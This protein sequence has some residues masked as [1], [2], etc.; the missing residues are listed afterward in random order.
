[1]C[2]ALE[3][4]WLECTRVFHLCEVRLRDKIH[5]PVDF[6]LSNALMVSLMLIASYSC[7][8]FA[9]QASF[10]EVRNSRGLKPGAF[11]NKTHKVNSPDPF[12]QAFI[13]SNRFFYPRL[14]R[15]NALATTPSTK[16]SYAR[17]LCEHKYTE[18]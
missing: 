16:M 17:L 9:T 11:R 1:M 6:I 5:R 10:T 13:I 7:H 3:C 14:Y 2:F 12:K 15:W 18:N 8:L 4:T